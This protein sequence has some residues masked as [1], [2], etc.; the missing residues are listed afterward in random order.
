MK[1]IPKDEV[2]IKDLEVY[3][4]VGKVHPP[5]DP[6]DDTVY[7]VVFM[8]RNKLHSAVFTEDELSAAKDRS[9]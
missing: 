2:W 1:W 4:S 7:S 6:D 5:I 8:Y 9:V 3:G